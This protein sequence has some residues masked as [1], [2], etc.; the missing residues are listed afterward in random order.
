MGSAG[1]VAIQVLG[2]AFTLLPG[3]AAQEVAPASGPCKHHSC[4]IVVEW[5]SQGIPTHVD[6]RYGALSEFPLGIQHHLQ[7]VGFQISQ[8]LGTANLIARVRP[9][10]IKAACD[11][12]AGTGSTDSCIT[13][14]EVRVDFEGKGEVPKSFRVI[15]RC[16]EG[17][18]M[19]VSRFTRYVAEMFDF[20]LS[21]ADD[22]KKRPSSKC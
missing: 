3:A 7:G 4:A 12:V 21:H 1:R 13:I 8:D 10:L 9:R 6:R 17:E 11:V 22:K 18:Y 5:G 20:Y 15:G 19:V 14:G 2:L 16:G